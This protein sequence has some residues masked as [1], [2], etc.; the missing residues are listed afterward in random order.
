MIR[1]TRLLL[2]IKVN[3]DLFNLKT[4][5]IPENPFEN[6]VINF[7][8]LKMTRKHLQENFFGTCC[9][10]IPIV[11][12]SHTKQ[13]EKFIVDTQIQISPKLLAAFSRSK[14][15][16]AV[17]NAQKN[18]SNQHLAICFHPRNLTGKIIQKVQTKIIP[19]DNQTFFSPNGPAIVLPSRF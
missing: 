6:P 18:C 3:N 19:L 17:A 12:E 4:Q 1:K 8:S 2:K 15:S 9:C 14:C 7:L 16:S 5:F 11:Q 13:T 10:V